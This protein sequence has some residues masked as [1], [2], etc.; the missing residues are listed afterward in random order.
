MGNSSDKKKAQ[1]LVFLK[2]L[3]LNYERQK[4]RT[5]K[6]KKDF[7]TFKNYMLEYEYYRKI[8]QLGCKK[9]PVLKLLYLPESSLNNYNLQM[10]DILEDIYYANYTECLQL[11]EMRYS[12]TL[13]QKKSKDIKFQNEKTKIIF[14]FLNVNETQKPKKGK[15]ISQK[16]SLLRVYN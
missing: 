3:T 4:D 15:T 13:F 8:L 16:N 6:E 5:E 14:D 1:D 9:N 7:N 2:T 12:H 10:F 11:L